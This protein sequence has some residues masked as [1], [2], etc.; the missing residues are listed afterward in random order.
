MRVLLCLGSNYLQ[1]HHMALACEALRRLPGSIT[2]TPTLWTLPEGMVSPLY[3]NSLATLETTL[4][5]DELHAATKDIEQKL[6][7]RHDPEH[8]REVTIDIDILQY[9]QTRY[10][11]KDW[12]RSFVKLLLEKI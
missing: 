9:D 7:R 10:K 3:L 8:R 4:S 12:Q 1:A 6:G 2:F 5:Y 11:E